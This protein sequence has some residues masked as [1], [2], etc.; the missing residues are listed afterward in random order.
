MANEPYQVVFQYFEQGD[1]QPGEHPDFGD[2]G[3]A[4]TPGAHIPRVGEAVQ[5]LNAQTA[6]FYE[7]LAVT[8]RI[9]AYPGQAPG[10]TAYITVGPI[11]DRQKQKLS[12]IRE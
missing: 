7:V 6:N 11:T 2:A 12:I 4:V 8:T 1:E 9:A 3:Y 10:W 5:L